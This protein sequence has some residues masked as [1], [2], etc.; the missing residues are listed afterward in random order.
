[1]DTQTVVHPFNEVLAIKRNNL[2]RRE[3]KRSPLK[4][5]YKLYDSNYSQKKKREN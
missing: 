4:K 1:M 2:S 3:S 5:D